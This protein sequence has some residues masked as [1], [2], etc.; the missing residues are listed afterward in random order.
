MI[1]PLRV[2]GSAS[3]K[4]I[5]SGLAIGSD[6]LLTCL[7]RCSP[8][9]AR[10]ETNAAAS[11]TR[12]RLALEVIGPADDG[13]FG[14]GRMADQG[15]LDFGGADAVAGDVEHVVDAA[16]DPE[17]A[18]LVAARAVAGEIAALNSLQYCFL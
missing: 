4:R 10:C 5:S 16:D 9:S 14:D 13:S 18:V 7:R 17:I 8:S 2:L 6:E 11:R 12:R 3:A 15:A 1:F